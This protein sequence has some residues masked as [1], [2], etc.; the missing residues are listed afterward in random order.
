M[1]SPSIDLKW[2]LTLRVVA[3]ALSCFLVAAAIA[4][5]ATYREVRQVNDSVANNVGRLLELQLFR[6]GSGIDVAARFPDWDPLIDRVQSAGQCIQY[7]KADGSVERSSCVGFN[8]G[9]DSPPAWFSSLSV[10]L[11]SARAD[12]SRPITYRGK[13]YGTLIVTTEPAAV[14][15]TIWKDVSGLLG[16]T[17]LTVGAICVLLYAAISRALR[18]TKEILAGLDRL[19]SGDLTCRLSSFRLI[20][21]Q[22]ISEVFNTLAASLDRTLRERSALAAKLVDG[23]EQERRRLARELHDELAQ[24]LSAMSAIA[25]SI[26]ATAEIECPALVPEVNQLT[27]TSMTIMKSLRATLRNLRPPEIDDLGLPAS[28]SALAAEQERRAGGT[29]R[30][31]IEIKGDIS[32]L[33]PTAASHVYRII[34]EGLTNVTKHANARR[35]RVALGFRS[36]PDH[37]ASQ[38]RWL[39]LLIEDDGRGAARL[40]GAAEGRGLGLIGM[41]ERVMALGGQLDVSA[42]E[43]RGFKLHAMIPLEQ[44]TEVA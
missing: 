24:S 30:V 40:D 18:P 32:G 22:R 5:Y 13:L 3:V 8:R 31:S 27:Q 19:A 2:S 4:F 6:I 42:V 9:S 44:R 41:R 16:L 36:D 7:L 25:A 34:Q 21:F 26:R 1:T 17:A 38:Q 20:E 10:W 12:V 11:L 43:E 39:A 23:Q 33:A 15:A 14:L 28:L 29:L 35:A 37:T